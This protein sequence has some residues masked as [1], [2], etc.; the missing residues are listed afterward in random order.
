MVVPVT[1][2]AAQQIGAPEKR[3]VLRRRPPNHDVVATAR[4][5]VLP[6]EHEFFRAQAGLAC[7]SVDRLGGSH[8]FIPG[9]RGVHVDFDH[10][11]VRRHL[12]YPD[13]RIEGQRISLNHDRHREKPPSLRLPPPSRNSPRRIPPGA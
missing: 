4:A 10:A 11:R 2:Q 12:E 13:A 6:V 8:Q 1:D 3:A 5:G 9:C 7:E